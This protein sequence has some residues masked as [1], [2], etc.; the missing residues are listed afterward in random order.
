[1]RPSEFVGKMY[2]FCSCLCKNKSHLEADP[3]NYQSALLDGDSTLQGQSFTKVYSVYSS[4]SMEKENDG[5]DHSDIEDGGGDSRLTCFTH[6]V[7]NC[8]FGK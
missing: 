7:S 8:F 2:D 3:R 4:E 5:V 6:T 1:M